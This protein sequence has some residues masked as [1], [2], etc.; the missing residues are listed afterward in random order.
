MKTKYNSVQFH[1]NTILEGK[2]SYFSFFTNSERRAALALITL[3]CRRQIFFHIL[4]F[5]GYHKCN[6]IVNGMRQKDSINVIRKRSCPSKANYECSTYCPLNSTCLSGPC[7]REGALD[8]VF[9]SQYGMH[10]SPPT[11]LYPKINLNNV[12]VSSTHGLFTTTNGDLYGFGRNQYGQLGLGDCEHRMTPELIPLDKRVDK[13]ACGHGYS[14]ISY[15][16]GCFVSPVTIGVCG[17]NQSGQL[18]C[19]ISSLY[20]G[21]RAMNEHRGKPRFLNVFFD[22]T[23]RIKQ[24]S[25]GWSHSV[26]LLESGRVY[27]TGLGFL[28]RLGLGGEIPSTEFKEIT[29]LQHE[30]IVEVSAGDTHTVVRSNHKVFLFGEGIQYPIEILPEADS[31]IGVHAGVRYAS[32]VCGNSTWTHIKTVDGRSLAL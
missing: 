4:S 15:Q 12:A 7:S 8:R 19:G 29:R 13:V 2:R 31:I 6:V 17:N 16:D 9:S 23:S 24:I 20:L 10:V 30:N 25:C 27:S 14:I 18:G 32:I 5:F 22:A 26:L 1:G 21:M 3:N 11:A 28:G